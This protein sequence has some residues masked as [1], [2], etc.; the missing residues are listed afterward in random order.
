MFQV[1][2][3]GGLP[4]FPGLGCWSH[5]PLLWPI[6]VSYALCFLMG[7]LYHENISSLRVGCLLVGAY[8]IYLKWINEW[9]N[10][11]I[12]YLLINKTGQCI[13]LVTEWEGGREKGREIEWLILNGKRDKLGLVWGQGTTSKLTKGKRTRWEASCR[14]GEAAWESRWFSEP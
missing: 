14:S 5:M 4:W 3:P 7:L 11:G 13:A 6:A 8:W 10:V 12:C 1:H 2:Y 9:L